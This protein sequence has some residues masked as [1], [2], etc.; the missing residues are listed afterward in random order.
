MGSNRKLLDL[1][2]ALEVVESIY[3]DEQLPIVEAV[4]KPVQIF[5][6]PETDIEFELTIVAKRVRND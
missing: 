4:S 6:A 3:Y 5:H 2:K 1:T